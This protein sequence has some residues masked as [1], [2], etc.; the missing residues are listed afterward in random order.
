LLGEFEHGWKEYEWGWQCGERGHAR[1]YTQPTWLGDFP[2]TGKALLI[3]PEQG[4][5][6]L[7]QFS[8][9]IPMLEKLGATIILEAPASLVGLMNSLSPK[10]KIIKEGDPFPHF[11][12]VCPVMSLPFALKTTLESIPANIPY[13]SVS[14]FKKDFWKHKLGNKTKPRIGIVWSGSMTNR[15]DNNPCARR[16]IPLEQMNPLFD[17]PFEFHVLQKE[18]RP[19]DQ[20]ILAGLNHLHLHHDDLMDFSDTAALIEEMDLV[21]SVC[22]SVAHLSG[23]LGHPTWVLLPYSADYRW[24]VNRNDSPWYPTVAI[25]RTQSIGDWSSVISNIIVQ[26]KV[27]FAN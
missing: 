23:A 8:R 21:I 6:D 9:Y 16:N 5:G 7:I 1:K 13:L 18:F 25:F 14:E 3:H 27:K 15:I 11:D 20:S 2:I 10:V 12:F 26:L 22:T 17:L 4:F 19:E 24:L